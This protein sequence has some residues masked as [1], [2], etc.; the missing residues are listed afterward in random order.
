MLCCL[1]SIEDS[2]TFLSARS[3]LLHNF[4]LHFLYRLW[5]VLRFSELIGPSDIVFLFR[6][7][8]D[9]YLISHVTNVHSEDRQCMQ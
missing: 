8:I 6:L 4:F 1:Q 7:L 9:S 2:N 5:V 3:V